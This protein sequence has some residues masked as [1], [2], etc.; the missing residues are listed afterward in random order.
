ML[1]IKWTVEISTFWHILYKIFKNSTW[2]AQG[3]QTLVSNSSNHPLWNS[4]H[5]T[6]CPSFL[7]WTLFHSILRKSKKGINNFWIKFNNSDHSV[8]RSLSKP[9][10]PSL[11][12]AI[13]SPMPIEFTVGYLTIFFQ[14]K[15]N[16]DAG[17]T[18]LTFDLTRGLEF[19]SLINFGRIWFKKI[20]K[21]TPAWVK[22]KS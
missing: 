15:W 7:A 11:W 13:I 20:Q 18:L 9:L 8:L 19:A 10:L 2:G 14:V 22:L 17:I 21:Q 3:P 12:L 5:Q 1:Y 4:V 16:F 6:L